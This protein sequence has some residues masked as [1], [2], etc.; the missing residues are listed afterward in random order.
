MHV[1]VNGCVPMEIGIQGKYVEQG[2]VFFI[3]RGQAKLGF[4]LY[5]SVERDQALSL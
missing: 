5:R 1:R 4:E 2:L 3:G